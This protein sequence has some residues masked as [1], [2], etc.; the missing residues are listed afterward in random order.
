MFAVLITS[1]GSTSHDLNHGVIDIL[2][3]N[4]LAHLPSARVLSL[5]Q[6]MRWFDL[7]VLHVI[8]GSTEPFVSPQTN[9]LLYKQRKLYIYWSSEVIF[10]A[11]ILPATKLVDLAKVLTNKPQS[12]V[13]SVEKKYF[14]TL[15][16]E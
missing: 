15:A 3:E 1:G 14:I 16:F 11:S 7:R 5:L 10:D 8:E 2:L 12:F 13:Q 9:Q 4:M 6:M